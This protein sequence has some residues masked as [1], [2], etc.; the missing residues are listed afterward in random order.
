MKAKA[1]ESEVEK[2]KD[3]RQKWVDDF[4][5]KHKYRGKIGAFEGAGYSSE[6]LYRP[7]LNCIMFSKGLVGFDAVCKDAIE[8]RIKFIIK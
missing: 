7:A 8:R 1:P 6:G 4:F 3:K 5:A 2:F